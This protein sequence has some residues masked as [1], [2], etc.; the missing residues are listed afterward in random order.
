MYLYTLPLKNEYIPRD[1]GLLLWPLACVR[2]CS[3]TILVLLRL[4]CEG[5][6]IFCSKWNPNHGESGKEFVP[7]GCYVWL[8]FTVQ[9]AVIMQFN[10]FLHRYQPLKIFLSSSKTL[11]IH[12][13]RFS[14][15]QNRNTIVHEWLSVFSYFFFF[16]QYLWYTNKMK[17]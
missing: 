10:P 1:Y 15:E 6:V 2:M 17:T 12:L 14:K 3:L 16:C 8:Q 9:H 11:D 7:L 13:Q 5:P 4:V